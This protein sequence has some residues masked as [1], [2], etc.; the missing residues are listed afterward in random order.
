MY[1]LS[2]AAPGKR[3]GGLVLNAFVLTQLL[4]PQKRE[5]ITTYHSVEQC[6]RMSPN[7]ELDGYRVLV[8]A[9]TK[10]AGAAL[11]TANN[12][13]CSR[14]AR[15]VLTGRLATGQ[16]GRS[17]GGGFRVNSNCW[18]GSWRRLGVSLSVPA[19]EATWGFEMPN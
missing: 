16:T 2:Y 5:D 19:K 11:V 13:A 18:Q 8:T 17:K 1:I 10:G 6:S 14:R 3:L 15:C 4:L 12:D 9:G 7:L